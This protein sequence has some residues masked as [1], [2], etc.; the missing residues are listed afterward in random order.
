MVM[1]VIKIELKIRSYGF[2]PSIIVRVGEL[3][4]NVWADSL[5]LKAEQ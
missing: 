3:A 1:P 4:G 5:K 2:L